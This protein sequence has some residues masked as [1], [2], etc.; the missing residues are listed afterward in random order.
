MCASQIL[1]DVIFNLC[2]NAVTYNRGDGTVNVLVGRKGNNAMVEVVDTGIGIPQEQQE[3]VFE[4]FY[5]A[6]K[7]HSRVTG[8]TGL[9]L[10]IV[11]RGVLYHNGEIKMMSEP[12][13]GTT[14]TLLLPLPANLL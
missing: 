11:K 10:S 14:I 1:G 13:K 2:E 7:S 6:D 3:R 9:G 8:G 4:R 12:G 5:R